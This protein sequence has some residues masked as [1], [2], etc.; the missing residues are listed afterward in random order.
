M[1]R[2]ESGYEERNDAIRIIAGLGGDKQAKTIWSRLVGYNRRVIVE[3]MVSRW[4]R[5]FGGSLKSHCNKRR[6]IEVHLK[7]MM[8]NDMIDGRFPD[9]FFHASA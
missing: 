3:S 2:K 1:L 4:K 8:I 9:S 6:I 5:L 7:A